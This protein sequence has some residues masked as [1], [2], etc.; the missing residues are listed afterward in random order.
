MMRA[1]VVVVLVG[2]FCRG[3]GIALPLIGRH[4]ENGPMKR[5]TVG[6][7]VRT[8]GGRGLVRVLEDA[9]GHQWV[10]CSGCGADQY[11]AGVTPSAVAQ[12]KHA[13]TCGR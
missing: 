12:R 6:R 2:G 10:A 7:A 11:S 4:W 5:K 1:A 9:K 13:Q 8:K 3:A